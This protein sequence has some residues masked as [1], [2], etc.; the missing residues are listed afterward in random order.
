MFSTLDTSHFEMSDLNAVAPENAAESKKEK[1]E[2]GA[3]RRSERE[4]YKG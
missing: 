4:G 3:K 1:R 2:R